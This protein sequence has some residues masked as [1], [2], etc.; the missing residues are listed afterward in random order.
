MSESRNGV[1]NYELKM[2]ASDCSTKRSHKKKPKSSRS[3]KRK[4]KTEG[5]LTT[6][7][8][9]RDSFC[10]LEADYEER[11]DKK[12]KLLN[13]TPTGERSNRHSEGK[14]RKHPTT[15]AQII[16]KIRIK[17]KTWED[18]RRKDHEVNQESARPGRARETEHA[19][20]IQQSKNYNALTWSPRTTT[21]DLP[22]LVSP[23]PTSM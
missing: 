16:N 13:S 7:S 23:G 2:T 15:E 22:P 3:P 11:G 6:E 19:R 10:E 20:M 4:D 21:E 5:P 17:A 8:P 1:P 18:K 14:G 12:V 9:Q